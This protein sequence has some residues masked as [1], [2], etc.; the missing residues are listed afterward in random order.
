MTEQIEPT[1]VNVRQKLLAKAAWVISL[2]TLM[3][4]LSMCFTVVTPHIAALMG[5]QH[6]LGMTLSIPSN[7]SF[8]MLLSALV[9]FWIR[10]DGKKD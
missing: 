4:A 5:K 6:V 10:G 9:G 3:F 7:D 2:V 1:K 8:N